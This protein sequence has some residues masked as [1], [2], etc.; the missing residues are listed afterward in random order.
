MLQVKAA[1][2]RM[3]QSWNSLLNVSEGYKVFRVFWFFFFFLH[4]KNSHLL[5]ITFST[6]QN[7]PM[8]SLKIKQCGV[9]ST[10]TSHS[11]LAVYL[12]VSVCFRSGEMRIY[13]MKCAVYSSTIW[14]SL[15]SDTEEHL[16]W[17]LHHSNSNVVCLKLLG[18]TLRVNNNWRAQSYKLSVS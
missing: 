7:F 16:W 4:D 2:E 1:C 14:K 5:I 18:E 13:S 10:H 3:T 8:G 15:S 12:A 17:C 11:T 6:F 9:L